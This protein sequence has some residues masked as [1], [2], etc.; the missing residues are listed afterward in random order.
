[1][2]RGK[3]G[4]LHEVTSYLSWEVISE[5]EAALTIVLDCDILGTLGLHCFFATVAF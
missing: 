4:D 5:A 2:I 3:A 1:M